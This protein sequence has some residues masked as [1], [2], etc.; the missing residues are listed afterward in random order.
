MKYKQTLEYIYSQLP[1][2]HLIGKKAYKAN[3]DNITSLDKYLNHP[4]Q[5]FQ[6]IHV[7]GTNGK[8][9]VSH[10]LASILQESGFKIGLFTSPH[11]K[12]FRERIKIDG[13]MISEE[14]VSEFVDLNRTYFEKLHPSFFEISV[15]MAFEYFA[16]N[17]VEIAVIEVGLGGR[18]DASNIISP[19]VSVI[20]NISLDHT[21]LLGETIEEIAIEK[22]GIIKP[23]TPVVIGEYTNSTKE[24]FSKIAKE[25]NA[26]VFFTDK[27]IAYDYISDLKG[28]YQ[29]KNIPTVLQTLK[30]L[31]EIL[32][33][34]EE[35]IRSG[36]AHTIKNTGLLGRW[37]CLENTP[38]T[39]C[40]T[41]HNEAGISLI[42]EQLKQEKYNKLHIVWGMVQDKDSSRILPLLPIDAK[43]YICSPAIERGKNV[44]ILL[45]EFKNYG[46]VAEKYESVKKA[47]ENA[48]K[49]A[50]NNDLIF[51]GGST[52]VVAE[53]I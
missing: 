14:F 48:K 35:A 43:Y 10:M 24:V 8:G 1:Q 29:K 26:P 9:S 50:K 5:H 23:K 41:G 37:Y 21:D 28:I 39:I 18:L 27:N 15:A 44:D 6:C 17:N 12:D 49:N 46:F 31:K 11:L 38:K 45:N 25:R 4:H 52:F 20:T 51:I 2:Y 16:Q 3:L 34:P 32:I 7:A 19:I 42:C 22:A 53:V 33:I 36:I 47:Y 30:V 13:K 40:D